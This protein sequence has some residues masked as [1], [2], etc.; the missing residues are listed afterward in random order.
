MLKS[1]SQYFKGF[2]AD[3]IEET[4]SEIVLNN[5]RYL[6][7]TSRII[8]TQYALMENLPSGSQDL[9]NIYDETESERSAILAATMYRQGLLDGVKLAKLLGR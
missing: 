8:E 3:R 7:L 2:I 9:V 6:E 4:D 5:R 1:L